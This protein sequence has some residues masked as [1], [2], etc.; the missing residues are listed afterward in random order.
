MA[1]RKDD[2][3]QRPEV[4]V[5]LK[6]LNLRCGRLTIQTKFGKYAFMSDVPRMISKEEADE[7][8]KVRRYQMRN[9]EFDC[10]LVIVEDAQ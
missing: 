1:K 8:I 6:L 10:D 7:L 9:T 4:Q 3:V 2:T 5:K